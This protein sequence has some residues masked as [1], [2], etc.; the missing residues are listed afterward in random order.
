MNG[1]NLTFFESHLKSQRGGVWTSQGMCSLLHP[2]LMINFR[3][4]VADC[5]PNHQFSD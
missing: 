1:V 3:K 4:T 2:I 5:T